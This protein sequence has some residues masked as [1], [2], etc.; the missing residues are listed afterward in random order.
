MNRILFTAVICS[1][2]LTLLCPG[3]RAQTQ[4]DSLNYHADMFQF[5]ETPENDGSRVHIHQSSAIKEFFNGY[6]MR[7]GYKKMQGFR[8]RVFFDNSQTARQRSLDVENHFKALYPD[9]PTY[10]IFQSLY[11]KVAVGDFRT[12]SDAM[13]FLR[14]ID[15]KY[16]G[17]FI[18]KET[19]NYPAL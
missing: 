7:N 15:S 2:F 10:R 13:R 11:F 8:V 16:S 1:L 19:I 5:L 18:I 17:A 14:T 6:L 12:K 4:A 3:L 9:V